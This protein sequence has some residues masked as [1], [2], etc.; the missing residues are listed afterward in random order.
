MPTGCFPIVSDCNPW[1]FAVIFRK[2]R[3][4]MCVA[5]ALT[6][7]VAHT[8]CAQV[9]STEQNCILVIG[10]KE[11]PPFA[12]KGEDGSWTGISIDLWRKIAA[13]L[14]LNYRFQEA[15]LDELIDGT[16]AG[17]LDAAIG[18]ITITA[19][20]DKVVDFTHAYYQSG[21]GIA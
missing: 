12:M 8:A 6:S 3:L 2:L 10:T 4:T 1:Y 14:N 7:L 15:S 21:L 11:A 18:A 20:R 5:I 9:P 13:D 17:S 16:A 19:E